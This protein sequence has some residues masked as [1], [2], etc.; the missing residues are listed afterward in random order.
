MA[1]LVSHA[2]PITGGSGVPEPLQEATGLTLGT[3]AVMVFFALSGFLVTASALRSPSAAH[4]ISGRALRLVPG[5]VVALMISA[6]MLGPLV[7]ML[8]IGTYLSDPAV[9]RFI[10]LNA[11][12]IGLEPHLPGV[13]ANNPY[14]AAAGPIWTLHYEA[15]CYAAVLVIWLTGVLGQRRRLV[16]ALV[17][18]GV[19]Y[20]VGLLWPE[21]LHPRLANL[22]L[23]SLPFVV[24]ACLYIWRG[25]VVLSVWLVI[26]LM[27][28]AWVS[29]GTA[30]FVPTVS[31]ALAYGVLV[32]GYAPVPGR[33][34][35]SRISDFSYG[36]YLYAF[37][38]QGL[39]VWA[40]GAGTPLVNI[41]LSTPLVIGLAALSWYGV[42]RPSLALRARLAAVLLT[43]RRA[44]R[45][46][47]RA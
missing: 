45:Q 8:P 33:G 11:S 41:L 42:E 14:P 23:L 5:L 36:I 40:F 9:L 35:M 13:F 44:K 20:V 19:F 30:L 3:L 6:L 24:G 2:W 43:M 21:A 26:A 32:A 38:V 46:P 39:M 28:A 37:P 25:R 27:L 47:Y 4:W 34:A 1:V 12:L 18:Y 29:A 17:F 31:V 22:H 7:T 10:V 16:C 15:L